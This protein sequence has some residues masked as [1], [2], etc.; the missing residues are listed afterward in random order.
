MK[1]VLDFSTQSSDP[2]GIRLSTAKLRALHPERAG[3]TDPSDEFI[4][5]HLGF[6]DSRAAVV[7]GVGP[8]LVAAYTDELDCVAML[9]FP[10]GLEDRYELRSGSRL[11]TVNTYTDHGPLAADLTHG[12]R[13]F[14]RYTNFIPYIAEF[15]SDNTAAIASRKRAITEAEW[16]RTE[17]L[18]RAWMRRTPNAWRDGRPYFAEYSAGAR[19]PVFG[20]GIPR[21]PQ[22]GQVS[23]ISVNVIRGDYGETVRSGGIV[24]LGLGAVTLV[25]GLLGLARWEVG[26]VLQ[27]ILVTPAA[28]GAVLVCVGAFEALTGR[29]MAEVS[30]YVET[31]PPGKQ[32]LVVSAI[33]FVFSVLFLSGVF[34][35]LFLIR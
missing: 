8:L 25:L 17:E 21:E 16:R 28:I 32:T 4:D 18:G 10:K 20:G 14:R 31:L 26:S 29:Q 23:P 35:Y 22:P 30:D 34:V 5:E 7:M 9:E 2:V 6:G 1:R 33:V 3:S 24:K 13:S 11:L 19:A 15:L 12:P 27:R